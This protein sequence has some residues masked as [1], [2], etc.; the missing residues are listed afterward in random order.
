MLDNMG[1]TGKYQCKWKSGTI[2]Y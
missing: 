2:L 1:T